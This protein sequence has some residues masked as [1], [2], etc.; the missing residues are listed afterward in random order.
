MPI[1]SNPDVMMGKPTSSGAYI[2]V[3]PIL[4]RRAA[5]ETQEQIREGNPRLAPEDIRAALG[6]SAVAPTGSSPSRN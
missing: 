5:G 4:E 3:E 6:F 2:T 1:I